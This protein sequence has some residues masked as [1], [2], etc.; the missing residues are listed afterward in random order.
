[1]S[2]D[3]KG[4]GKSE[5]DDATAEVKQEELLAQKGSSSDMPDDSSYDDDDASGDSEKQD[6][7]SAAQTLSEVLEKLGS[8][9]V[10]AS[11]IE[12]PF[13][14][15]EGK[16]DAFASAQQADAEQAELV[17]GLK[18]QV[19][20]SNEK[21]LR[22]LA[23]FDNYKKNVAKQRAELLKYQGQ[24]IITDLLTTFDNFDY[25]LSQG[26]PVDVE[27][28]REG[29]VMIHKSFLDTLERWGVK[30]ETSV[31]NLFDP[32][33]HS[34]L[35]AIVDAEKVPGTVIREFK[36]AF[37]YKDKLLRPAE[38]I[39]AKE[40]EEVPANGAEKDTDHNASGFN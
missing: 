13:E 10:G 38:V 24:A 29:I 4:E 22:L 28:F 9:S 2:I 40:A 30:G 6:L 16:I 7:S 39:V 25:A 23:E 19:A 11:F 33:I 18:N 12:S 36:R 35:S 34:A 5:K 17:E 21:Y 32:A 14:N 15:P 37:F 3:W 20:E 8:A 1:V 26:A 31:G 27:S